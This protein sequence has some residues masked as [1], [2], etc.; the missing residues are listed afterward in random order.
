MTALLE[1][2]DL[3][4]SYG[5]TRVLHGIS[6][7]IGAGS[8]TTL[9][10]ADGAGKT[11]TLRAV[12]G[13]L[14]REAVIAFAGQS[15]AQRE[16]ED[17]A[18]LGIAHVPDG[19]GSFTRLTVEG[20]L[21]AGGIL[22]RD[23]GRINQDIDLV[24]GYFPI[25]RQ[26]C[27]QQ[28]ATLSGGEQ[29]MLAV[30]RALM[31]RTQHHWHGRQ[32]GGAKVPGRQAG[33]AV[34]R[35]RGRHPSGG[36]QEVPLDPGLA[37]DPLQRGRDLRQAHLANLP[38]AKS[39]VISQNDDFG[40]DYLTGL[41]QGLGDKAKTMIVSEATCEPSDPTVDPQVLK[42]TAS[43]ADVLV[44]VTTPKFA[45]QVIKNIAEIGWKPTHFLINISVSVGAVLKPAGIENSQGILSTAYLMEPSDARWKEHPD[46]KAWSDFMDKVL[47]M[48]NKADSMNVH[49]HVTAQAM[50]QILKHSG[51]DLSRA[52]VM[53][54]A[55]SLNKRTFKL[56]LPGIVAN[57]TTTDFYPL[58]QLQM[59]R[60]KGEQWELFGPIISS[61]VGL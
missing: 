7:A 51:D 39:A 41:K 58:Q 49:G 23:R 52:K 12:C 59:M 29:Q 55:A 40:K 16:T 9:L 6:L 10:G 25:L 56:M 8:I 46:M 19:R 33:G 11:S 34:A 3:F 26:R 45:A 43:G 21:Q 31:S 14:R 48:A 37:A 27:T 30:G 28:A 50:V 17:I 54:Q 32:A 2:R 61:G 13:V 5:K 36:R 53:K 57:T 47:P 22:R 44:N 1:V 24:Y 38:N 4:A 15:T 35:R 20:N 18:R 60:L 42:L